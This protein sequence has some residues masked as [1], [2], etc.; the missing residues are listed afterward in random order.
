MDGE[1]LRASASAA[2]PKDLGTIL[3]THVVTQNYPRVPIPSS[4][5]WEHQTHVVHKHADKTYM[6][7]KKEKLMWGWQ[8]KGQH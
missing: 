6:N 3:S 1:Q 7:I 2:L 5:L 4:G 8:A